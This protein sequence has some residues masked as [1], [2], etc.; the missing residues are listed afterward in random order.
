MAAAA[1]DDQLARGGH[2]DGSRQRQTERGD[3][4]EEAQGFPHLLGHR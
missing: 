4:K 1:A 3:A 2:H